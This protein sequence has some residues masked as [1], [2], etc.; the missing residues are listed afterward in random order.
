MKYLTIEGQ[1]RIEEELA[2][3]TKIKRVELSEQLKFATSLGDLRENSE[4]QLKESKIYTKKNQE[5]VQ[6]GSKVTIEIENDLEAYEIVGLNESDILNNKISYES[7]MGKALL[8]KKTNDI[9]K[10]EIVNPY[11]VKIIEI[12]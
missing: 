5:T 10:V 4:K 1:K 2:Y 8:N 6:I 3:L 9:V 7:P 12:N 11:N